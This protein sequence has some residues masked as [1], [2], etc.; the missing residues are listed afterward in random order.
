[1]RSPPSRQAQV[2]A[3]TNFFSLPSFGFSLR[4]PCVSALRLFKSILLG[5]LFFNVT[6][7]LILAFLFN[8]TSC[9]V[10]LSQLN[11][12]PAPKPEHRHQVH[13]ISLSNAPAGSF[14]DLAFFQNVQQKRRKFRPRS[15]LS[16]SRCSR[17]NPEEDVEHDNLISTIDKL[18][19]LSVTTSQLTSPPDHI[20]FI[21][22]SLFTWLSSM[23]S[24]WTRHHDESKT[25]Q[26][27]QPSSHFSAPTWF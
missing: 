11:H 2:R 10:S 24:T 3:N 7:P 20:S 14:G 27:V 18:F 17:T 5:H 9:C 25:D 16:A 12:T 22:F 26:S 4:L 8:L 21:Y 6:F 19:I 1:M 15:R 23:L 13:P